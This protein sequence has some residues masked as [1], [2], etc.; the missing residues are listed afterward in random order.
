MI[1][2]TPHRAF[3][4]SLL[5]FTRD[6]NLKHGKAV[7]AQILK[8]TDSAC[9]YLSN[10]L[11]NLYAKCGCMHQAHT[12]FRRTPN[13]DVVSWNSLINGYAKHGPKFSSSVLH[14]FRSMI[15]DDSAFPNAHTLSGVLTAASS[16]ADRCAGIQLHGYV[17]K[18][19]CFDDLFVGSSL[20]NLYCKVGT[21]TD[22]RKVF[23]EMPERNSVTWSTL[24]SG[25][26]GGWNVE[27]S[28]RLF[29]S[30]RKVGN[31][32]VTEFVITSVVSALASKEFV[33]AGRQLHGLACKD[34]LLSIVEV[35]NAFVTMYAKCG[36]LDDAHR[37]FELS[38]DKNAITWS[39]MVTGLAQSGD[40]Q[41]ALNLFS[42][43]HYSG[44]GPSEFTFVGVLNACSDACA[45][46]EGKQTHSYALKSGFGSQMYIMTALVDMYA[47]CGST[48]DAR[49]GFDCLHEPDIVL[50]T[51]MIA[52]HVQNGENEDA[53]IL[54]GRMEMQGIM[55]NELTM[56]SVLKACASLAALEQG[57]QIHARTVKY[58][59][60]L[61]VPIGSAMSTMY[62]KCGSLEDGELVFRR[63]PARDTVCWNAMI[64]GLSQ[65]GR[66]KEALE[67]FEEMLSEGIKPDFVTF[68]NVLSS[69]SHMGFVD[70]GWAY[71][72]LMSTEY[73]L[74]PRVEHYACMVDILSRAG[75]L[76]AAKVFIESATVDHG[77]CLWRILLSAARNFR[78]YDI[79]TYAG[80]KLVELGSPESSAYVLLSTVYT[81]LG[82]LDDVERVRRLMKLRGVSKSP[83]CSWIELKNQV[84]V[85]VVGDQMHPVIAD[86]RTC[87]QMLYRPMMDEG[88]KPPQG[89]LVYKQMIDEDYDPV[90][91]SVVYELTMDEASEAAPESIYMAL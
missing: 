81:A 77:L 58:G 25:Y 62:S 17:V 10:T 68:V 4:G 21:L 85:F 11:L 37:I 84:H 34:G 65:N 51:S 6:K 35:G 87:L 38:D 82:Q 53:L 49:K 73:D 5:Q 22:A 33:L 75:K 71:F 46:E 32:N 13:K 45:L 9:I 88:Y 69:C 52:G 80:E 86:I 59:F 90:S 40:A 31:E 30:L 72:N 27:E 50:W 14:L 55:P 44:I 67:L 89:Q 76:D 57:K 26:A 83:G 78:N 7:H 66:G 39:A 43:M 63:I 18:T 3:F 48:S 29:E 24:I 16:S 56:S 42:K 74:S 36:S 8:T 64:S 1:H 41:K 28:V 54:Y 79:G 60:S 15:L 20:V 47:K 91:E 19:S 61:E 12:L 2:Q 23:D 70:K